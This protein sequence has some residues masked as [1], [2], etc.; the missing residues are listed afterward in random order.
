MKRQRFRSIILVFAFVLALSLAAL[1]GENAVP[2]TTV[3]SPQLAFSV[4]GC[5]EDLTDKQIREQTAQPKESY[6][7]KNIAIEVQGN[8]LVFSHALSYVCCA[9]L[10]LESQLENNAIAITEINDGDYCR[11][12]CDYSISASFGP[13]APGTYDLKVY[14]IEYGSQEDP[15]YYRAPELLFQSQA[16]I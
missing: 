11:C 3:E 8:N 14:G 13:L 12:T 16:K 15:I 1:A 6:S 4:G 10:R 2:T 5:D 9:E 7:A